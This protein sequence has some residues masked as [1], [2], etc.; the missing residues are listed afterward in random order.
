MKFSMEFLPAAR[1]FLSLF[2][3][4]RYFVETILLAT[5]D[6]AVLWKFHFIIFGFEF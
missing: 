3:E 6:A 5:D 1:Y 4:S 2:S